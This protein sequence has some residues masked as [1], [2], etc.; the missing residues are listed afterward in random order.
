M[1]NDNSIPL[2]IFSVPT[3]WRLE[4]IKNIF[5]E[6]TE[7]N[8]NGNV[9]YL[10]LVKDVGV[11][12]YSEKG[13]VGNKT[14]DTPEKYKMVYE[15]DIVIN[16]MNV[17]IGSVGRSK[18]NGCLS[19]VYIVLKPRDQ[20][21]SNFYHYVFFSKDFQR[22][23]K[24]IATG[25]MEIRES[26]DK[27]EFFSEKLPVPPHDQQIKISKYLDSKTNQINGLIK[28]IEFKLEL[29]KQK[30]ISV[31]DRI[32]TKSIGIN[33]LTKNS[34]VVWLDPI[35][36]DWKIIKLKFISSIE[37]SSVDR[38]TY[39]DEISVNICHYPQVYNNEKINRSSELSV[40]TCSELEFLKFKVL[41]GDIL[42]TKDSETSEDIGVPS[43]IDDDLENSVC[44]Y[45][46]SQIRVD[47][48]ICEPEFVFR[49]LQTEKVKKYFYI[50]SN[51]V[52]RFGLGKSIIE[53]LYIPFPDREEQK[54]IIKKINELIKD[55]DN[56][57]EIENKR[58]VVLKEYK[59]SLITNVITGTVDIT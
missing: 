50:N 53:N 40:G 23:L 8:I 44:G 29:L 48:S 35:P 15:D 33:D 2:W 43:F 25:I 34:G 46:L 20:Y 37:L 26:I 27:I 41:K 5:E 9:N 54:S 49:F 57:V 12:P 30:R 21:S 3:N 6:R 4:K 36:E 22:Y 51:G 16:P 7:K 56:M 42:L 11:I 13:N 24:R 1:S 28:K 19:S 31:V 39:E 59:E 32:F 52:T 10:S 38:H 45:H 14:S 17:I 47:Q 58:I 55:I 18:Y